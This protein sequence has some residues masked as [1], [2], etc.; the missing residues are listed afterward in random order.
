MSLFDWFFDSKPR[1][2]KKIFISFS[3]KD[4]R[5]RDYLVKQSRNSR[6]PF[7][8]IDMSVKKPWKEIEWKRKCRTKIRKCDGVIVLL[9]NNT[10][11]AGGAR[12]EM[13]CAK[14]ENKPIIGMHIKKNDQRAIP[15]ELRNEE[16]ITWSWNNIENFIEEIEI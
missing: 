2:K 1:R 5:Y 9:S 14:Q 6:S 4:R 16:I 13:K 8:F 10:W 11:H 15:P 3:M 7:E 12:W